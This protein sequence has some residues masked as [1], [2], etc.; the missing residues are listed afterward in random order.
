MLKTRLGGKDTHGQEK[1]LELSLCPVL[2]PRGRWRTGLREECCAGGPGST[3]RQA[4]TPPPTPPPLPHAPSAV[5]RRRSRTHFRNRVPPRMYTQVS[6]LGSL[7]FA[8]SASTEPR[9]CGGPRNTSPLT[10]FGTLAESLAAWGHILAV[11]S[12]GMFYRAC[13]VVRASAPV[14]CKQTL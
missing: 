4:P 14:L 7:R 10:R 5:P 3:T 2:V 1:L 13:D 9:G 11:P 12:H 6:L 8:V